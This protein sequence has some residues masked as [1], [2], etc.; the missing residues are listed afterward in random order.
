VVANINL[1]EKSSSRDVQDAV[2]TLSRD[3]GL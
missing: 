1:P 2:E 3:R